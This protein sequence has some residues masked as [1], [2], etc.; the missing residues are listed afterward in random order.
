MPD[1]RTFI[2][3]IEQAR[4]GRRIE[5]K[6]SIDAGEKVVKAKI[7]KTV[8]A[9]ANLQDGGRIIIGMK[10]S[11][12][13]WAP[14][15]VQ[16]AHLGPWTTD[17]IMDFCNIYAQPSIECD[18]VQF[19]LQGKMFVGIVVQEFREQPVVCRLEYQ[20]PPAEG[21]GL[22]LRRGAVYIRSAKK[23]ETVE[24]ST[25]IEMREILDLAVDKRLTSYLWRA[26]R[27]GMLRTTGVSEEDEAE[28][29]A[30]K[31]DDELKEL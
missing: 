7:A 18:V 30:K 4:E 27:V 17:N 5:F 16:P 8:M 25:E 29:T 12:G 10:E 9:M 24:V 26:R 13:V 23:P 20:V 2:T 15:G 1:H 6:M 14:E 3:L 31:F 11:A 19:Q 21:P 28:A 22:I